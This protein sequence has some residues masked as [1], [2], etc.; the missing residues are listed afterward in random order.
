MRRIDGRWRFS[1][2]GGAVFVGYCLLWTIARLLKAAA[3]TDSSPL[4]KAG[5]A[6]A[7]LGLAAL[8]RRV[9]WKSLVERG[10][11]RVPQSWY[12]GSLTL[13]AVLIGY[14]FVAATTGYV[15]NRYG[16]HYAGAGEVMGFAAA[17]LIPLGVAGAALIL[18]WRGEQPR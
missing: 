15:P 1:D 14:A 8:F 9:C 7:V 16:G 10:Q 5:I 6:A 3:T 11:W 17:A 12:E 13:A 18:E 2:G 4:R